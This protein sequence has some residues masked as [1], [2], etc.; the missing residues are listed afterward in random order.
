MPL[1]VDRPLALEPTSPALWQALHRHTADVDAARRLA[2]RALIQLPRL[3]DAD[4]L[5]SP[6][7]AEREIEQLAAEQAPAPIWLQPPASAPASPV[8][9]EMFELDEA[10]ARLLHERFHYLHSHRP[11]IHLAGAV[12][13]RTAVLLSFSPLD[14]EPIRAALPSCV[15]SASAL[16]LSRVYTTTWAPRN[17]LSRMLALAARELRARQP[18]LGLLLTYLNPGLG[19]DGASYKAANW[20]LFGREHGTRYA[21]LDGSYVTDR[22]LTRRFGTSE[23][24]ALQLHL[25]DRISF[26]RMTL[27][28]LQLFAFGLRPGVRKALDS[29]PALEWSRPWS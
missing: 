10:R 25:A 4:G 21:Y 5:L 7:D 20:R 11:G 15:E 14:L 17:S 13:G 27:E 26:S 8:E 9:L 12:D 3:A 2:A 6:S 19:F 23:V 18:Q 28:P 24:T 1:L 16:V 22:E 29:M